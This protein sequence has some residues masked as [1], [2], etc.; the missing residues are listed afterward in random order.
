[1]KHVNVALFVPHLGCPH[2]CAFCNQRAISG[3]TSPLTPEMIR[4]AC[5]TARACPHDVENSEIAFFGGSFTAIERDEML[6]C[7]EAAKPYVGRDFGGVRISTRPDGID[8][9]VL[10]VL[11]D[12]GVTAIELGA[13]SMDDTILALNERGHTAADTENAARLIKENGFSLGLQ[14]MTGLYGSDGAKDRATAER[15]V[16]LSPDT[17]RIYPTVVLEHTKLAELWRQGSYEP[18]TLEEAVA[19]CAGLLRLFR[20]NGIRVIRLGLH[21][22]GSVAEGYLAGA[23]HPAFGELC[24]SRV[25]RDL[26]EERFGGLPSGAYAVYVN[27]RAVSRAIGHRKSNLAYFREKGYHIT[28]KPDDAAGQYEIRTERSAR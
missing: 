26:L 7:L 19:L 25:Y 10:S 11:K 22:G 12:Y 16:K 15:F 17:V 18:P 4:D 6:R 2:T 3:Q 9:K 28:V 23:Y 21:S 8:G 24:E 27:P 14:M 5:E 1:M 13:Q 20:D